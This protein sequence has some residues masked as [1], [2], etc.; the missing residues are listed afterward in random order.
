MDAP[1]FTQTPFSGQAAPDE[2][3]TPR[4]TSDYFQFF[5]F[6]AKNVIECLNV[7]P[8]LKESESLRVLFS[9]PVSDPTEGTPTNP[10]VLEGTSRGMLQ[11]LAIYVNNYGWSDDVLDKVSLVHIL[12]FG[13]MWGAKKPLTWA[14]KKLELLQISPARML[15]LAGHYNVKQWVKPAT[16]ALLDTP[17]KRYTTEDK[18]TLGLEIF[19]IIAEAQEELEYVMKYVATIP[20]PLLKETATRS[21][22]WCPHHAHCVV[23][24]AE[25]WWLDIARRLVDPEK[26]LSFFRITD[27]LEVTQF[28][29]MRDK[30]CKDAIAFLREHPSAFSGHYT[31]SQRTVERDGSFLPPADELAQDP[32]APHSDWFPLP[33]AERDAGIFINGDDEIQAAQ[34]IL[35]EDFDYDADDDNNSIDVYCEALFRMESFLNAQASEVSEE[36]SDDL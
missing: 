9:L 1:P 4:P 35:G 23:A 12:H 17:L 7:V 34:D 5:Y 10:I 24:W 28:P 26:P 16:R 18:L 27:Q 31:V 3:P 32:R 14:I 29:G 36:E 20:P 22:L 21:L 33:E 19:S 6:H 11:A 15:E 25:G 30:C 13:H 2:A 8:F